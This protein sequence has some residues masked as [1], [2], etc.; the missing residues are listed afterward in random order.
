[1]DMTRQLTIPQAVKH[2]QVSERTLRRWIKSS[3]VKSELID[4]RHLISIELTDDHD[5]D[6]DVDKSN[7]ELLEHTRQENT[8]LREQLSKKDKQI[9]ELH[10]LV[11]LSQK[12]VNQ[13]T[14]QNLLLLAP[15]EPSF[16]GRINSA[17]KHLS[18]CLL[19][20]PFTPPR[21]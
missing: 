8:H 6:S 12:S 11:A 2:Y 1:M 14:E 21:N 3:K 18:E 19:S 16:W 20:H 9:D 15:P 13:L 4:G 5:N 7:S 10:Q 17:N